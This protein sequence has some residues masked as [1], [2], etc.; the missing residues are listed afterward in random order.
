M[1]CI[2]DKHNMMCKNAIIQA[3]IPNIY[4][5]HKKMAAAT[6]IMYWNE[7]KKVMKQVNMTDDQIAL[8]L[9]SQVPAPTLSP[10][11][12]ERL[13]ERFI[14]SIMEMRDVDDMV[15]FIRDRFESVYEIMRNHIP[16]YELKNFS[17]SLHTYDNMDWLYKKNGGALDYVL[18]LFIDDYLVYMHLRKVL[19]VVHNSATGEPPKLQPPIELDELWHAHVQDSRNYMEFCM[20]YFGQYLHHEPEFCAL[21]VGGLDTETE[22]ERFKDVV[23]GYAPFWQSG[24]ADCG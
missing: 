1:S 12:R 5:R 16:D 15:V 22:W 13:L 11:K 20:G 10:E 6:A 4:P 9:A 2:F 17:A 23:H 21:D 3:H 14:E 7:S 19:W 24:F 8:A 18:N